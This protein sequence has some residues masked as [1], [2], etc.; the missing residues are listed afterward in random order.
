M[1]E[2]KGLLISSLK[3]NLVEKTAG[4]IWGKFKKILPLHIRQDVGFAPFSLLSHPSTSKRKME[5]IRENA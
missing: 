2:L 3:S 4:N 1:T 5:D